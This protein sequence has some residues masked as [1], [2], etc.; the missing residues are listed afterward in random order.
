MIPYFS[1]RIG[2]VGGTEVPI[3]AGGK[4]NGRVGNTNVGGLVVGTNDRAGVVD[5]EAVMARRPGEA[6][7]LARVVD[8]RDRDR[9][10]I[11]WDAVGSW[12]GGADF[13]YATSRFRGDKNFLVGV[14]GLA[15]DRD[16][17]RRRLDGATASRSTIRTTCGTSR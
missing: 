12:L 10:A 5:D 15:T 16:G 2:L 13:T 4:V 8:R 6:E 17:R 14:W 11:R 1:R 7:P 3:I 9:R